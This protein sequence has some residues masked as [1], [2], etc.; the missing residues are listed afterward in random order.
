MWTDQWV[1]LPYVPGGRGPRAFDCFGLVQAL[2]RARLGLHLPDPL[3]RLHDH[4]AAFAA[5]RR[6]W[7]RV[8]PGEVREGDA[9][10]FRGTAPGALH[11]AMAVDGEVLVHANAHHMAVAYEPIAAAVAR[12]EGQGDGPV[13]SRRR[14]TA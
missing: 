13:T 12:I 9:L 11:V 2:Y 4:R 6:G 10:V 8:L 3:E 1:G 5:A 14:L 7:A